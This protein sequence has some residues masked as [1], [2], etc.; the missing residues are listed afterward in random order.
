MIAVNRANY[1]QVTKRHALREVIP[2]RDR[3][4]SGL[5]AQGGSLIE[6]P[7]DTIRIGEPQN[8][9]GAVVGDD[10]VDYLQDCFAIELALSGFLQSMGRVKVTNILDSRVSG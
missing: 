2:F 6:V 1:S 7:V 5:H 4:S 9:P 3:R 8:R 10:F